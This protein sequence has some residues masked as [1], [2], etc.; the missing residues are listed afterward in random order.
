MLTESCV[1][2]W[3]HQTPIVLSNIISTD[4]QGSLWYVI[5]HPF[6]DQRR[7]GCNF[8]W[9]YILIHF[10]NPMLVQ[11]IYS[12]SDSDSDN[13][14]S[15][16]QNRYRYHIRFYKE[17]YQYTITIYSWYIMN[18]MHVGRPP[19][20]SYLTAG[21]GAIQRGIACTRSERI[22]NATFWRWGASH[23]GHRRDH[24]CGILTVGETPEPI[25]GPDIR[26][27]N[28]NTYS[29]SYDT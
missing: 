8:I 7:F 3:R 14:Y 1:A 18:L 23:G 9:M 12:D 6:S 10:S 5:T 2:I 21:M 13:V 25:W 4:I 28:I 24:N 26:R 27:W 15:T 11:L 22:H 17:T 19:L 16:G 29:K 20:R